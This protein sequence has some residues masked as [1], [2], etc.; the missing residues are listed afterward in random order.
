MWHSYFHRI[1]NKYQ[2]RISLKRV[3][4]IRIDGRN[5]TKSRN[6]SLLEK[7]ENGF[8]DCFE[9]TIKIFT[10]KHNC[11]CFCGADEASFIF[12]N[13]VLLLD[14][15]NVDKEKNARTNDIVALF[16]QEFFD[17]FNSLYNNDKIFW[18]GMCFSIEKEK[19]NSYIKFRS[20][21]VKNVMTTYFL[22]RMMISNAGQ[23]KM[24]ERIAKNEKYNSYEKVKPAE[25]GKL[26]L[27][28]NM[29]DKEEFLN[30]NIIKIKEEKEKV[31]DQYFDI[32]KWDAE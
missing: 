31:E 7:R 11:L 8:L 1:E 18:H 10:Q 32:T 2:M 4:V 23:I 21:I 19:I 25:K 3:L 9:R 22:K 14:N 16:T 6:F 30:G 12:E 27:N 15:L 5:I 17:C 28:G 20:A 24:E 29:I 26:Y 13:P